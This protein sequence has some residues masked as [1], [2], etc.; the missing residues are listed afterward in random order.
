MLLYTQTYL[1]ESD[2]YVLVLRN[3]DK[4]KEISHTFL[5]YTENTNII[6]IYRMP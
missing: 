2:R 3:A 4:Y 6:S 1:K 5:D